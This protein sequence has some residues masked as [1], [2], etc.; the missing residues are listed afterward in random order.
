MS[1]ALSSRQPRPKAP[2]ATSKT[3]SKGKG[4]VGEYGFT[5]CTA[6]ASL[7]L[8][9]QGDTILCLHHDTLALERRF[10]KHRAN[11]QWIS[12]D[13]VSERGAGRF[14]VSY[15]IGQEAI[16]WDLY[17]GNE[18]S[19]FAAF[20]S[21]PVAAWM[22]NGHIAF[23][24]VKGEVIL[25]A[26]ATS[27]HYSSRTIYDPITALAPSSDCRTFAIGYKNGSILLASVQ[28]SFTI[29]HSLPSSRT[30]SPIA[31]LSWHAS[32]SKQKSDMLATQTCDGD[33]RVW[34]VAKPPAAE[35]P[36]VIRVLKRSSEPSTSLNWMAWS[37]NGR[38]VQYSDRETW[39]WDVRTKHVTFEQIPTIQDVR[40]IAN[41]GPTAVLFTLGPNY[42]VQQ[43]D[44]EAPQLV[45][46]IQHF[47]LNGRPD[48]STSIPSISASESEDDML[49]PPDLTNKEQLAAQGA[50]IERSTSANSYTSQTDS[51]SS[52]TSSMIGRTGKLPSL[53]RTDRS[54]TTFSLGTMSHMTRGAGSLMSGSSLGYPSSA[55]SPASNRAYRKTSRLR[56]E[57]VRSPDDN[58]PLT[59]LFPSTRQRLFNLPF[60]SLPPFDPSKLSK[61]ALRRQMLS[62]V[63]G[64]DDD[65][66]TLVRN[67]MES[68]PPGS[69]GKI[70]LAKWLNDEADILASMLTSSSSN[71]NLDWMLLALSGMG[72]QAKTK[73]IAQ[74]VAQKMLAK[75]DIHTAV[76]ILL[77][78]NEVDIATDVYLGQHYYMEAILLTCLMK[79]SDWRKQSSLVRQWGQ[80]VVSNSQ[81]HL[82]IRCF[83]VAAP[84]EEEAAAP[85]APPQLLPYTQSSL[86]TQRVK[87]SSAQSEMSDA[88]SSV[89]T[90]VTPVPS[91][92]TKQIS[93]TNGRITPSLKLITSFGPPEGERHFKFPGLKSD[94]RTPTVQPGVTPIAES[95]IDTPISAGG[96]GQRVGTPG[97]FM[98]PR[99]PS[100]GES[101]PTGTPIDVP[102]SAVIAPIP[103]PTPDNSEVQPEARKQDHRLG[104]PEPLQLLTSAKYDPTDSK[105]GTPLTALPAT[106]NI[107]TEPPVSPSQ[108]IFNALAQERIA[109]LMGRELG[110]TLQWPAEMSRGSTSRSETPASYRTAQADA[111]S[112][113]LSG[114]STNLSFR[115][116][117]SPSI[118]TRSIDR[119]TSPL[120]DT[121]GYFSKHHRK[122]RHS[123]PSVQGSTPAESLEGNDAVEY[124]R[125]KHRHR[126]K[127]EDSRGRK[128]HQH[129]VPAIKRSPSSPRPM[130][131]EQV[132]LLFKTSVETKSRKAE[133]SSGKPRSRSQPR[134]HRSKVED[135][136]SRSQRST[137]RGRKNT[138][139]RGSGMR[140]PSSPVPMSVPPT[141][142]DP[143]TLTSE[144]PFKFITADMERRQDDRTKV[145]RP[146]RG[147]SARRDP[148]PDRRRHRS[149]STSR[150]AQR[151]RSRRP[152]L[153]EKSVNSMPEGIPQ[154]PTMNAANAVEDT[155]SESQKSVYSPHALHHDPVSRP[156]TANPRFVSETRRKELAAAELEARRASLMRR[157]SVPSIPSPGQVSHRRSCSSTEKANGVLSGNET[158]SSNSRKSA[159]KLVLP[160]TPQAMLHPSYDSTTGIQSS[161]VAGDLVEIVPVLTDAV[162][163]PTV[164]PI[165]R[166]MSAPIEKYRPASATPNGL[167]VHPAFHEHLPK[168]RSSS[169][170]EQNRL[171]NGERRISP[172]TVQTLPDEG[173][174][175]MQKPESN[176]PP[177]LA[178]LQHLASPSFP[179]PP[180]PPPQVPSKHNSIS[181]GLGVIDIG[182][183]GLRVDDTTVQVIEIPEIG[184]DGKGA[185]TVALDPPPTNSKHRRGRSSTSIGTSITGASGGNGDNIVGRFKNMADRMRSS[186]RGRGTKSPPGDN[187]TDISP[188]ESI[189]PM[190]NGI[191]AGPGNMF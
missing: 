160:T 27:E 72:D 49:E 136:A 91:V 19:R 180:P 71:S 14:V 89:Q 113:V 166:S 164:P 64:W 86:P 129:R 80:H 18:V 141:G 132:S 29:L 119:Y 107:N 58:K 110:A 1:A 57:V 176:E 174:G 35:Q 34:S 151:S 128:H 23:G 157:P 11:I 66:E 36:R 190:P 40:A 96:L 172:T 16:V 53:P 163:K 162:Y 177:L 111:A 181:N 142:E 42:S 63:F 145:R 126:E 37:K 45:A 47:P 124:R 158:E 117:Q 115:T 185:D 146:S 8:Y 43:Y 20:E 28:P 109:T 169:R 31:G 191:S 15:D 4:K 70:L 154:N 21:I 143:S 95:A 94:D 38:I 6:T 24:N 69:Q 87:G 175:R 90:T 159:R 52:R 2:S 67:E 144:G 123:K 102:A 130:S 54:G 161:N 112:S 41:F 183:D 189:P 33:L 39:S 13:N 79:R 182:L 48:D 3:S 10:T 152:S 168:S 138:S 83:S 99:L 81:Q 106:T 105:K 137:S 92:N 25:F 17:N 165:D 7:L 73:T 186:S 85:A 122:I 167:P 98:R 56:N 44:V 118:T 75:G 170:H 88:T 187:S 74:A 139:E 60:K 134:S 30:P 114:P 153:T 100:I 93:P 171:S 103:L 68:H 135:Q 50:Q 147:T 156:Q 131:P 82:A 108:P 32:S 188:Y 179:P 5:A 84:D 121:T 77:S 178:E 127:S 59:D 46:N 61:D 150:Q 22:R 120:D 149:R 97:G 155:Q 173:R 55:P 76:T 12:V 26:P 104:S 65:I 184:E 148:S 62:V 78:L 101:P 133:S 125:S 9:A 140:S 116:T 51:A